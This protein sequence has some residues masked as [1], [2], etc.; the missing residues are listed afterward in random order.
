MK[1]FLSLFFTSLCVCYATEIH[2]TA[3]QSPILLTTD[4]EIPP[5]D[6]L[7]VEAGVVVQS[8]TV[9]RYILPYQNSTLRIVGTTNS[10]VIFI[11]AGIDA[12]NSS[13][14]IYAECLTMTNGWI[15]AHSTEAK[16]Q[17]TNSFISNSSL[18]IRAQ[19]NILTKSVFLQTALNTIDRTLL[20]N[21]YFAG[22]GGSEGH[23]L[24]FPGQSTTVRLNTFADTQRPVIKSSTFDMSQNYWA[25]SDTNVIA[26]RIYDRNDTFSIAGYVSFQP[27]LSTPDL[28]TP[29]GPPPPSPPAQPQITIKTSVQLEF[30]TQPLAYYRIEGSDDFTNW[31]SL[32]S[33]M[34][35]NGGINRWYCPA[36]QQRKF[37]RVVA[38]W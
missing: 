27:F 18:I 24:N 5:G 34:L 38:S 26:N 36:D 16:C 19:T 21:N 14:L 37:Y 35:G 33:N 20:K 13:T 23:L 32:T 4:F 11:N 15:Q 17:I 29:A 30:L 7:V 8:P 6:T 10:P 9:R 2:W 1:L 25:T 22:W 31:V 12:Y 28:E 3:A